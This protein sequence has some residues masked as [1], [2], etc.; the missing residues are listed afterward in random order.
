MDTYID[1]HFDI[2]ISEKVSR[3]IATHADKVENINYNKV[4]ATIPIYTHI[5]T[6]LATPMIQSVLPQK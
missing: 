5:P 6:P 2:N 4:N 3:Q 1:F